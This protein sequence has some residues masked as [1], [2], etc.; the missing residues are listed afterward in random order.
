MSYKNSF[1]PSIQTADIKNNAIGHA[2]LDDVLI[3]QALS[4]FQGQRQNKAADTMQPVPSSD[5]ALPPILRNQQ[6]LI[7]GLINGLREQ[8]PTIK[9]SGKCD[10][11]DRNRLG[12]TIGNL[13]NGSRHPLPNVRRSDISEPANVPKTGDSSRGI[14]GRNGEVLPSVG[15]RLKD[16]ING[17]NDRLPNVIRN[18][19]GDPANIP[20]AGDSGRTII[21][22]NSDAHPN[23]SRQMQEMIERSEIFMCVARPAPRNIF[24]PD[25]KG[26]P[27]IRTL[28]N[29]PSDI[30]L[31][32]AK[33]PITG[34]PEPGNYYAC[35]HYYPLKIKD[36]TIHI[37][38]D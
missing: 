26:N 16:L 1:E 38:R 9:D 12:E 2:D 7:S 3:G 22:P 23:I 24:T 21:E 15:Q 19:K 6:D 20:K 28:P 32:V 25:G 34:K 30:I 35:V 8:A 31:C 37:Q 4:I 10:V 13:I 14:I 27:E 33:T 18:G 36:G 29:G 5:Q 17:T 11:V